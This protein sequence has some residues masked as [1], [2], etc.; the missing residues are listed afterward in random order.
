[1]S[2][3]SEDIFLQ[4]EPHPTELKQLPTKNF[5]DSPTPYIKGPTQLK[6]PFDLP[7]TLLLCNDPEQRQIEDAVA[8]ELKQTRPLKNAET[9]RSVY[10]VR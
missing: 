6:K 2:L 8:K 4:Q 10:S 9:N 7:N 1:M 5:P 3:L